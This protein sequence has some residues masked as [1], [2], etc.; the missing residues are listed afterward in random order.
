MSV[1]TWHIFSPI[2]LIF[3]KGEGCGQINTYSI[4]INPFP[5]KF[6][7]QDVTKACTEAGI[8]ILDDTG[9]VSVYVSK[10]LP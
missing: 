5:P 8:W 10:V 7:C 1:C 4:N 6:K 3:A 9:Q 2:N